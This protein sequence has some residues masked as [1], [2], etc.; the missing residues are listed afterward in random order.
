MGMSRCGCSCGFAAGDATDLDDHLAEAFSA[1]GDTGTDGRLHFEL[2]GDFVRF[3]GRFTVGIPVARY[4]CACGF[5]ADGTREFDGHL[6]AVFTA[7][8][9]VGADGVR[10]A[11][12]GQA[13]PAVR[14]AGSR[15]DRQPSPGP[16]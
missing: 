15:P 14:L 1:D 16:A 5:A 6:L 12:E 8:G 2:A 3:G 11:P 9:S 13:A 7:P 10:H 4:V